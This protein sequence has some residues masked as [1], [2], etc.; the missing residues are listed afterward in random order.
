[1]QLT[2]NQAE[3]IRQAVVETFG[4]DAQ[5]WLFGSRVDGSKRGG[6]IDLLIRPGSGA[7]DS[8]LLKKIRLLGQF[9]CALGE[10]KIDIVIEHHAD[11]RPIV[12]AAHQNGIRL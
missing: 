9:E 8:L 5:V 12:Q 1:M 2:E 6:D 3:A 7:M 11:T 4:A 10:R